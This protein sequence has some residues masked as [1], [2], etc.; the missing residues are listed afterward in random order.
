MDIRT[1]LS[2]KARMIGIGKK[3]IKFNANKINVLLKIIR[4]SGS[5]NSL[6]KCSNPT[7]SLCIN[8]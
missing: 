6:L 5:V 1:S 8:P 2:I 3:K 4:N 7:H